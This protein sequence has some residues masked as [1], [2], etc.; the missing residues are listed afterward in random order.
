MFVITESMK[1]ISALG[2][3]FSPGVYDNGLLTIVTVDESIDLAESLEWPIYHEYRIVAYNCMG[4]LF[5]KKPDSE[6]IGYV[7]LQYGYGRFIA[8]NKVEWLELIKEDSENKDKFLETSAYEY[9]ISKNG[10]LAYGSVYTMAPILACGGD[11]TNSGLDR[12]GVG[13]LNV[14][15]SI[16]SQ[17]FEPEHWGEFA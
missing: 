9:L 8:Q 1:G 12:C 5:I 15:L 10:I 17:S 14:Y 7:W 16:V 3:E 13:H 2:D 11:S 4:D 6:Q